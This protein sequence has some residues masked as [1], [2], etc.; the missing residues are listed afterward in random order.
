MTEQSGPFATDRKWFY[1]F[2]GLFGWGLVMTP[3]GA[4]VGSIVVGVEEGGG[5]GSV[6]LLLMSYG[7]PFG[8][9]LA[10]PV[11]LLV[12]PIVRS[13]A[14]SGSVISLIVLLATGVIAG[15][16]SPFAVIAGLT[17]STEP[18]RY[19][20]DMMRDALSLGAISWQKSL[21]FDRHKW[22]FLSAGAIAALG[23]AWPYFRL[24]QSR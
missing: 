10:V 8:C 24:T 7:I 22:E 14:P 4:F 1:R 20:W 2:F 16:I 3:L 21:L 17:C 19:L 18:F 15:A 5:I 11:T 6:L 13:L 23:I 12:F 9:L